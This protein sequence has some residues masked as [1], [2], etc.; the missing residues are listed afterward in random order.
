MALT[1]FPTSGAASRPYFSRILM[2]AEP[3]MAPS[4]TSAILRACSGVEIPKP[5]AH[6]TVA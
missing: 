5:M 4:D 3:T 2:M 6:G 1:Y